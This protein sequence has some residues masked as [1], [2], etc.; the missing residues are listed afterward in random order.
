M[1][2]Y[3]WSKSRKEFPNYI[4]IG[5]VALIVIWLLTIEW[6]PLGA[7]N[8][9]ALNLIFSSLLIGG[10][11]TAI[12]LVVRFYPKVLTWAL[13]NKWKFLSIP[14]L[15]ILFGILSWQ[16]ANRVFSFIPDGIK[17]S[18]SWQTFS[19]AF[20]GIGKEFNIV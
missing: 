1:L 11:L 5:I 9:D 6:M 19:K 2:E 7:K 15:V 12:L 17:E 10:I 20:P 14:G 4:N 3:K 8:S 18:A 16:G 13:V